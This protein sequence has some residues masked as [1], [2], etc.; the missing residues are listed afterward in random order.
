MPRRKSR[1]IIAKIAAVRYIVR[2]LSAFAANAQNS[3]TGGI[4]P[5]IPGVCPIAAGEASAAAAD[6]GACRGPG[7]DLAYQAAY[8]RIDPDADPDE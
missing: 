7:G 8:C 2:G 3:E 4:E 6:V 5:G 1:R